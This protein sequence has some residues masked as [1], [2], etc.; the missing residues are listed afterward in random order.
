M[1]HKNAG[2]TPNSKERNNSQSENDSTRTK[3]GSGDASVMLF[4]TSREH[5]CH[6][7]Y[8]ADVRPCRK[9]VRFF[10]TCKNVMPP[11]LAKSVHTVVK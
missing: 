2:R 10:H 6:F 3:G 1:E 8:C 7:F 4:G 5:F 9:Q 11:Q